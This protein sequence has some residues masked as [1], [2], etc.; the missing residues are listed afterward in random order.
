MPNK[1]AI[2]KA[3]QAAGL[4]RKQAAALVGVSHYTWRNWEQGTRAMPPTAWELFNL[5]TAH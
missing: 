5:K 4:S 1:A 3:R 2:T